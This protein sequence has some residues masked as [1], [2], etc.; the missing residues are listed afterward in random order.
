MTVRAGARSTASGRVAP[1]GSMQG[2]PFDMRWEELGRFLLDSSGEGIYV[3][4]RSGICRFMNPSAERLLGEGKADAVAFG[5]LAIANPDLPD[6]FRH[7]AALND[8]DAAT[9]YAGGA[10]GYTDYPVQAREPA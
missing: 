4:D 10:H 8:W 2:D 1:R 6:R 7:G 5:K 3:I 9:F